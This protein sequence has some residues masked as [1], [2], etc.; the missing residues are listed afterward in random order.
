M[1]IS[2]IPYTSKQVPVAIFI[3]DIV[4]NRC[5]ITYLIVTKSYLSFT[6]RGRIRSKVKIRPIFF[7]KSN[8][9]G[10][11]GLEVYEIC[12]LI[13]YL[14]GWRIGNRNILIRTRKINS[15]SVFT[16]RPRWSS[17]SQ[18]AVICISGQIKYGNTATF[19]HQPVADKTSGNWIRPIYLPAKRG[20]NLRDYFYYLSGS[21]WSTG[22]YTG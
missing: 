2:S 20:L 10:I 22:A 9:S 1:S 13:E 16:G 4:K 17:S 5:A 21:S 18:R 19:I 15:I 14:K 7:A 3:I 8:S 12:K 6:K 11:N